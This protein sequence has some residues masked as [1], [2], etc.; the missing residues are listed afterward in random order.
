MLNAAFAAMVAGQA[1][2]TVL[3][4]WLMITGGC[5]DGDA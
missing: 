4:V 2:F 3:G 5:D 1:G